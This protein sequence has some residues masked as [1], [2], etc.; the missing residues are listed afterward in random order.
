MLDS[1]LV[2]LEA[3]CTLFGFDG[4]GGSGKSQLAERFAWYAA[5]QKSAHHITI[6]LSEWPNE[7]LL[8]AGLYSR[9]SDIVRTDTQKI[10]AAG[11]R[12]T[13]R[14]VG[15]A[16]NVAA[17]AVADA[18]KYASDKVEN[19]ATAVKEEITGE[20]TSKGV[21]ALIDSEAS[22]N[23]RL[24]LQAY[25][26]FV[27]DLGYQAYIVFDNYEDAEPSAQEIIRILLKGIPEYWI[28]FV[29][30]NNEKP[31]EANWST[32]MA[33]LIEYERGRV[34]TVECLT[35]EA[36]SMFFEDVVGRTP[37]GGEIAVLLEG[38]NG[39]RPYLMAEAL[40]A[41]QS[42]AALRPPPNLNRLN[43]ARR[44]R[45]PEGARKLAELI[46]IA[47]ADRVLSVALVEAAAGFDNI[48]DVG[49]CVDQLR[50]ADEVF[51][52]RG[53][54]CFTHSSRH[55]GWREGLTPARQEAALAVWFAVYQA[56]PA[57]LRPLA[58]AGILPMMA[59]RITASQ[60]A[61]RT[62]EA[63][64]ALIATGSENEALSLLDASWQTGRGMDVG[65]SDV[66]EHA[67]IAAQTRLDLG[68]YR[69]AHEALRTVELSGGE[70]RQQLIDADMI[71]LKLALRQNSYRVLWQLSEKIVAAA[72]DDAAVQ[73][74]R[75]LVMNTAWRD[76]Y[77]R[78][79][80]IQSTDVI[81]AASSEV[82][83]SLQAKAGRSVARSLAKLGFHKE[84]LEAATASL[85]AAE[86]QEDGRAI[87]NAQLALA[88]VLRAAGD[89]SK[90]IE[91][92][93]AGQD[94]ARG[95]G[96]RDSEIWCLLGQISA[97][98]QDGNIDAAR[99]EITSVSRILGEPGYDHPLESA[100]VQLL[101]GVANLL[102]GGNINVPSVMSFY[103]RLGIT[104]PASYIDEV[105][106]S[107]KLPFAIPI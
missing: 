51:A 106:K 49:S 41:V 5:G 46:A 83:P 1:L 60:P 30:D 43:N 19:I 56:Q 107:M 47:P 44:S 29:V 101:T 39:G 79:R 77:D 22:H 84:A 70:T 90:A 23:R 88:E 24:F 42:G 69:E 99:R 63:A 103:D 4:V 28:L 66:I 36:V 58:D 92:Y 27:A 13:K 102:N 82:E 71:R 9:L 96:N 11:S 7:P 15:A 50:M 78:E 76:L 72:S 25:M 20:K 68:R 62:S 16:R 55:Q 33:P 87:G 40:K 18:I 65:A 10:E 91:A 80:I 81:R 37:D 95:T 54:I 17:A 73:L 57:N 6:N 89:T 8:I 59:L 85:A 12:L 21:G 67:L 38:T 93:I 104:W 48:T 94:W 45:I 35:P 34:T 64:Q 61:A 32:S 100:H 97:H 53:G 31:S 105:A 74:E 98:I 26:Q 86:Q 52:E 75:E 14:L 2:E 3:G